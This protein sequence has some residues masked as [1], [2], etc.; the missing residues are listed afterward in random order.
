M[1]MDVAQK[2]RALAELSRAVAE[3]SELARLFADLR[4]IVRSYVWV[5]Y[6]QLTLYDAEKRKIHLRLIDTDASH[7][8]PIGQTFDLD[9][10]PA[11]YVV[12]S[13]A[14]V[15]WERRELIPHPRMRGVMEGAGIESVVMLPLVTGRGII[16][17]L[18]VGHREVDAFS[19]EEREF[20]DLAARHIGVAVENALA[21]ERLAADRDRLKVILAMNNAIAS[22][23]KMEPLLKKI[24]QSV[25]PMIGQDYFGITLWEE[26]TGAMVPTVIDFPEAYCPSCRVT[27]KRI[28]REQSIATEAFDRGEMMIYA[29]ADLL[30]RSPEFARI[31]ETEEI[32]TV[33]VIPLVTARG[34]L[35]TINLGSRRENAFPRE[36]LE[37]LEAKAGQVAI[38]VENALAYD[39]IAELNA[40][41]EREKTY[42]VEEIR[43][44]HPFD[45]IIGG[46]PAIRRVLQQVELVAPTDSTVLLLGE[47]GTGKELVARAIHNRS[48]RA[49]RT[50]VKLNCAAIPTGLI[51][52]EIFG[53]ERGAFT[54]AIQTKIGRFELADGGSL[55]LD[56]IGEVSLEFQPKLLRVLQEQEFERL[57]ATRTIRSDARLIAATNRDLKAMVERGAFRLDLYYRLNIVPIELPPLRARREDVALLVRH[58][59]REYSRRMGRV[60]T[61]IPSAAIEALER[62]DWPGNVR[63]L[64][65]VIERSVLL[66]GAGVLRVDIESLQPREVAQP[67]GGV[68]SLEAIEREAIERA[69]EK[70]GGK[71]G[72]AK[73]AAE[74][75]GLKRTTL[76]S[77]MEKLGIRRAG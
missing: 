70:S 35:G 73:G 26:A 41:L 33:A 44:E 9:D 67:V 5:E 29:A 8:V 19:E 30:E 64:Q 34:K 25:R 39:R 46:S 28:P 15:Y 72:G 77:R 38:A 13:G 18:G 42:L 3:R 54:G 62:Y 32:R 58:Y 69:L 63:E 47:S 4:M 14:A 60:I 40:R 61:E 48:K 45:E 1:P 59:V 56:E 76:I 7:Q 11:K 68:K 27:G 16:G 10:S 65:N 52:S 2:F 71:I 43:S 24:A 50:F 12:E 55:F 21:Q 6:V 49:A 23:L 53:H 36:V 22:E 57:G 17:M 31:A 75:L 66:S 20:L 37:L 74:L 51:E